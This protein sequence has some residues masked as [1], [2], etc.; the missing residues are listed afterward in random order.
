MWAASQKSRHFIAHFSRRNSWKSAAD[1][2]GQ[3]RGCFSVDTEFFSKKSLTKTDLCTGPL[4]WRRNQN[5][6]SHFLWCVLLTTSL[7]LRRMSMHISL[8]TVAIPVNYTSKFRG[9]FEANTYYIRKYTKIYCWQKVNLSQEEWN[10]IKVMDVY[11][12]IT[13][14]KSAVAQWL[15]C[16]ATN[17]KI[18]GSIPAG[19][20][21]VLIDIKS[22]RSH[23]GPGV[24]SASNRNE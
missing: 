16:C 21:G 11:K 9:I 19:V 17:R 23:Y 10:Y 3:Y 7:R 24:D 12:L 14:K 4:W 20:I 15:S 6:D 5:I 22:F 18:A 8:F 13:T 2:S 1:S